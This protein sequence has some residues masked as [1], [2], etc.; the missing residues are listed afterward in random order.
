MLKKKNIFI[1]SLGI[2]LGVFMG[3]CG[4]VFAEKEDEPPIPVPVTTEAIPYEDLRTF[5]EIFGRIKKDYVEPVSDKKLLEDAV[6]GMLSGLDPHSAYLD[7]EEYQ[8]LK[9]GTSGQF[10][11]LGIEVTME[12]GFIKVVSPIDDTPA[13]KAGI[14][15][16]DLIIKLDD[17]PVKG[18]TLTEAVKHM[19]GEP[20]SKINLLVVREGA[21][22][23]LKITITRD[24]IKV[25]SVKNRM[26]EKNY[27]YVRISSF[28][29]GTGDALKEALASLKKEN[30]GTLKG[31]V[32][33]L[34]NNPG[35]VLNAAVEVSDAFMKSGLIVYTEGRIANSQMRFSAAPDDFIDGAPI[36]VLI[37]AGSASASEIVAGALQDS[38]R[39]IIMGEKSFGKGSVQTILPTNT[40]SA[41]KLT[42][43]RYFTPSGRSIQAKG[44][45]P[46]V[47]LANVKLESLDKDKTDFKPVKEADLSHHLEKIKGADDEK[48]EVIDKDKSIEDKQDDSD[49]DN[50]SANEKKD[51]LDK[52]VLD[53]KDYPL[54]EALNL[55]K[56]ISIMRK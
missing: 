39:A 4:S 47:A 13:Q 33:D 46:D 17:K 3:I 48:K 19:R 34:R 40:G 54:Y 35:G 53:T 50:E 37:N 28:Q 15:A 23:P 42:T 55:L 20:G 25:K 27:A 5:T 22:A 31:L 12:N 30:G 7:A 2:M 26:L 10:G 21:D 1:L 32:L 49:K 56:G 36:V 41:V 45:E 18:M 29:S 52:A 51:D 16:G 6:K 24:I 8:E 38:K 11:G 14:K 43:A 44:I 9:E